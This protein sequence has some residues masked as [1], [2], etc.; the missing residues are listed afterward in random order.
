MEKPEVQVLLA[1]DAGIVPG[2]FVTIASLATNCDPTRN[3]VIN[4]MDTGISDVDR[5]ALSRFV[6][7][8]PRLELKIHS[9]D[10]TPFHGVNAYRGSY[11]AYARLLVQ[12]YVD[13]SRVI[14]VD[15]DFLFLKD[16]A[17]LFDRDMGDSVILATKT[18]MIP[19]LADD[20][21]FLP[22]DETKGE[23]YLNSGILLIDLLQWKR[24]ECE[25]RILEL[26]RQ[27]I[28]L[29][30]HDQTLLNFVLRR[31]WGELDS[32]WGALQIHDTAIPEGTNFHFGGGGVK[33]WKKGCHYSSVPIWW[34]YYDRY[35]RPYYRFKGDDDIRTHSMRLI[36][37]AHI[38]VKFA[39]F[40]TLIFSR[41]KVKRMKQ[42]DVYYARMRKTAMS[43]CK[44]DRN[45]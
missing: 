5:A 37:G 23:P 39:P 31:H 4:F 19:T 42:R 26:L 2:L 45:E 11:G 6:A 33:P 9:V 44:R 24:V 12:R 1:G 14:Y 28:E 35:V 25:N 22:A 18:P 17:K 29:A 30:H 16:A 7:T 21:P 3:V 43:V 38:L 32:S 8:F 15:T 20:C 27:P 40:L 10:L 34:A 41:E 13:A 36:V